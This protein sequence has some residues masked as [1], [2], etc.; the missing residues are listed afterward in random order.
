M[1]RAARD[2]NAPPGSEFWA[3]E[4]TDK[5]EKDEAGDTFVFCSQRLFLNGSKCFASLGA[6]GDG[7]RLEGTIGWIGVG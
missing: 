7:T 4:H 2:G 1:N 6:T 3:A 5:E